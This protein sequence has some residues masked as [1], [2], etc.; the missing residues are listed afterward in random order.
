MN[1]LLGSSCSKSEQLDIKI[2]PN[3]KIRRMTNKEKNLFQ[4][5]WPNYSFRRLTNKDKFKKEDEFKKNN[6]NWFNF[7]YNNLKDLGMEVDIINEKRDIPVILENITMQDDYEGDF[8][9][10]R[11]LLYT[12]RFTAKTYLFGPIADSSEG[13]I[14]K[15]Q[16][17]TYTGDS[18]NAS[19]REMRYIVTP[20]A[21][22]DYN[23]LCS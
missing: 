5:F 10:R 18:V 11:V 6:I 14:K 19:R 16:V 2:N 1:F 15:V 23:N 4:K 20:K 7:Y 9:S 3:L 17:D 22:K 21:K 8:T 12:L 13:L